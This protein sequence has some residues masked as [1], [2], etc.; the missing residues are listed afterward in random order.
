LATQDEP[1]L[2]EN[3]KT[4]SEKEIGHK[5]GVYPARKHSNCSGNIWRDSQADWPTAGIHNPSTSYKEILLRAPAFL[6]PAEAPLKNH[7][8][9]KSR[10]KNLWDSPPWRDYFP[11]SSL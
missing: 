9:R 11:I 2:W 5:K 10:N 8:T 4:F 3:T 1:L 6:P 7:S